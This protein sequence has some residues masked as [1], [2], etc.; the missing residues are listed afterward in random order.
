MENRLVTAK[1][2]GD[3]MGRTGNLGLEDA[4]YYIKS[5]PTV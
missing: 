4:N 5:G 2:E 1:G 3:G